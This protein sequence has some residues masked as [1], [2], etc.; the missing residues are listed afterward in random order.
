MDSVFLFCFFLCSDGLFSIHSVVVVVVDFDVVVIEV[1]FFFVFVIWFRFILGNINTCHTHSK[2]QYARYIYINIIK[3]LDV[4][5]HSSSVYGAHD[6]NTCTQNTA[7]AR[8]APSDGRVRKLSY[9]H[10]W[11][12]PFTFFFVFLLDK[13]AIWY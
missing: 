4:Y 3:V 8:A 6:E 12:V 1:L 2:T 13:F 9:T 7:R 5:I 10:H 11:H